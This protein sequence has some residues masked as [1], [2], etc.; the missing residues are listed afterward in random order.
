MGTGKSTLATELAHRLGIVR[1][2]S[3]DMLREVMR[4]MIPAHLMP[5][6]HVS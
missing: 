3:T 6:L 4:T 5:A 2:Q 1:T